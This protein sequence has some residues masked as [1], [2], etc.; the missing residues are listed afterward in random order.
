MPKEQEN[1][2]EVNAA[3]TLLRQNRPIKLYS[4][5]GVK[6]SH[7]GTTVDFGPVKDDIKAATSEEAGD[8]YKAETKCVGSDDIGVW[9]VVVNLICG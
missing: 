3:A 4:A 8:A 7:T 9:S 1:K 2:V 5:F 6:T